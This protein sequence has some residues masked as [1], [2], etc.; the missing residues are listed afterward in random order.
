MIQ[1]TTARAIATELNEM[2]I[3]LSLVSDMVCMLFFV[4]VGDRIVFDL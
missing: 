1:G 4:Y 2:L 3:K